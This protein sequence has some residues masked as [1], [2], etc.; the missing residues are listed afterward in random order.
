MDIKS[1]VEVK[2]E[3]LECTEEDIT[4]NDPL[5]Q[6][7]TLE[8]IKERKCFGFINVKSEIEIKEEILEEDK[9]ND[10]ISPFDQNQSLI[11]IAAEGEKCPSWKSILR[12][13]SQRV[14]TRQQMI[15]ES[16]LENLSCGFCNFSFKS[17]D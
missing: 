11:S 15:I 1:E 16:H 9:A 4:T 14:V 17:K 7:S 2:V 13:R 3:V 8:E 10:K 12:S 6:V 5:E